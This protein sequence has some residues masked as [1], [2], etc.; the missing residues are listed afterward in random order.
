M[1]KTAFIFAAAILL[2]GCSSVTVRTDQ[3][4]KNHDTPTYQKRYNYYWW[5]LKGE[6]SVNVRLVCQGKPVEQMQ[7]AFTLSD[8]L[9]GLITIGIYNPRTARVWCQEEDSNV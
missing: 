9:M 1:I 6:H 7:T 4:E 5:G 2:N 8:T 3:L